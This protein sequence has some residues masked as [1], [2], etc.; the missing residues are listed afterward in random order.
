MPPQGFYIF[1]PPEL[2]PRRSIAKADAKKNAETRFQVWRGWAA[3]LDTSIICSSIRLIIAIKKLI[4]Y[5]F[6]KPFPLE[7]LQWHHCPLS[8]Q[9]PPASPKQSAFSSNTSITHHIPP[10]L[11]R[12]GGGIEN[13]TPV[14]S[15]KERERW[16]AYLP[17]AHRRPIQE[18]G[19]VSLKFAYIPISLK[20]ISCHG[21]IRHTNTKCYIIS[22][23]GER[24]YMFK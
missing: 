11:E 6:S 21:S 4:S 15:S 24:K 12:V 13:C 20:P 2:L 23:K 5:I 7:M 17:A 16:F 3:A 9:A 10:S 1:N 14:A 22:S 18:E 19:F 8:N